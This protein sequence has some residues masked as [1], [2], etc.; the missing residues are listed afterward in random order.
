[1]V[2]KVHLNWGS[3][4]T[5]LM[6]LVSKDHKSLHVVIILRNFVDSSSGEVL[7]PAS[8]R[9]MRYIDLIT[10][11]SSPDDIWP[12]L[13]PPPRPASTARCV[14]LCVSAASRDGMV[15]C[16]DYHLNPFHQSATTRGVKE[17]LRCSTM[18]AKTPT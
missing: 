12:D 4:P 10:V 9:A 16:I 5:K 6:S 3:L 7:Q 8:R 1:M 18:P 17:P 2:F 14:F 13:A 11:R 15:P